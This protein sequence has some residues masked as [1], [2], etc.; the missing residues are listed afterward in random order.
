MVIYTKGLA[1]DKLSRSTM[2][3]NADGEL[4]LPYHLPQHKKT[5]KEC[6]IKPSGKLT[7]IITHR[8]VQC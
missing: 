3:C 5:R 4:I 6:V 8:A 1:R 2:G 7:L